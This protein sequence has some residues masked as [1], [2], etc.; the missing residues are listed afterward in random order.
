MVDG[1]DWSQRCWCSWSGLFPYAC[2][3]YT[4]L[5]SP[6]ALAI[7]IFALMP[8][9]MVK[10][11]AVS[12]MTWINSAKWSQQ[13]VAMVSNHL[14]IQQ[15]EQSD[16]QNV[17][18]FI[19]TLKIIYIWHIWISLHTRIDEKNQCQS[20]GMTCSPWS[21]NHFRRQTLSLV[22]PKLVVMKF[23]ILQLRILLI[24]LLSWHLQCTAEGNT[25]A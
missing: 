25:D 17:L 12:V 18:S 13:S 22:E 7:K 8:V 23:L 19:Y 24:L 9:S 15:F 14:Q 4:I 6:Q 10:E 1:F 20:G 21:I 16:V 3:A 5:I 2:L 11:H